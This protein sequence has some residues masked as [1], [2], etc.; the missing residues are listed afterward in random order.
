MPVNQLKVHDDVFLVT[1][2]YR[3]GAQ[4]MRAGRAHSTN[5]YR[6]HC[7]SHEDWNAGHVNESAREHIRFNKDVL[8]ASPIG[9]VFDMDPSVPR[10]AQGSVLAD[11]Y[12]QQ[13]AVIGSS[14]AFKV[15]RNASRGQQ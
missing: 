12:S 3:E 13:R 4:A 9:M 2:A 8:S 10:D 15:L 5:P 6:M 1:R 11:W 7:Q 14:R